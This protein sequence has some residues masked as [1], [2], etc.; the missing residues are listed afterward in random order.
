M[1]RIKLNRTLGLT[2]TLTLGIGTMIGAGIFILPSIATGRAGPAASISYL[3]GGLIAICTAISLSELATGVSRSGGSYYYINRSLGPFFGTITGMGMWMGLI[4]ASAFYMIGF[5]YYVSNILNID[6]VIFAIPVTTRTLA[7]MVT[8]F[9]IGINFR[10]TKGAGSFQ[11]VIVLLLLTIIVFYIIVGSLHIESNNLEP[12]APKG[13]APVA[14]VAGLVFIG[15]M[16]FEVVATVAEEVRE[17]QR[18]LWK[19]MIGSVVIVTII[20]MIII[21]VTVGIVDYRVLSGERTPVAFAA[22]AFMGTNGSQLITIAAIFATVSSAH[23][24]ILSASRISFAMGKDGIVFPWTTKIH[25]VYGT[26]GN[27]ILIT[28]LLIIVFLIVGKVELL[29]ETAGFMFLMT[30]ALLHGCVWVLRR[31]DPDWYT[32]SFRAPLFPLFQIVGASLCIVLMMFLSLES[33]LAGFLLIGLSILWYRGYALGR[34][35]GKGEVNQ[36]VE[37]MYVKEATRT[38]QAREPGKMRVLVPVSDEWFEG[39]KIRL[40]FLITGGKGHIIRPIVHVV[41]DQ[42]PFENAL[43]VIGSEALRKLDD[44][45]TLEL[46]FPGSR[47]YRQLLSHNYPSTIID[48]AR[49][50]NCDVLVIGEPQ[51]RFDPTRTSIPLTK[52]LLSR[53]SVDTAVLSVNRKY[54]KP[55]LS[56]GDWIP[57][58]ILVP[59][60]GNPHTILALQFARN[61]A[62]ATGAHLTILFSTLKRDLKKTE[63]KAERIMEGLSTHEIIAESKVLVGRSPS[64]N[65]I[66]LSKDFDLIL[67]GASK[68]WILGKF[69]LGAIPDRVISNAKCPV[70]VARKWEGILLSSIKGKI[71]GK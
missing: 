63:E 65:I 1:P 18:N 30:F 71:T 27:A 25:R 7:V 12:F 8:L 10:G 16:G 14:G 34:A 9:L 11:N 66:D 53:G 28:G 33:M 51:R 68:T 32:P 22:E 20:Y 45:K 59:F 6:I 24:S 36:V 13:W 60:D 58:R 21:I 40:A 31:S 41:P 17:P 57:K 61:I 70:L 3:I 69:L 35:P 42:T 19:G 49:N 44:M 52:M 55:E 37:E 67:M 43:D 48:T 62:L 15:F 64:K 29:A 54:G 47:E 56:M 5:E 39:L 50:E 26:P 23:A 2:N 38:I 46:A 4:F